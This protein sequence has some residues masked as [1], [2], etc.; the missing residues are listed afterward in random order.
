MHHRFLWLACALALCTTGCTSEAQRKAAA[1]A[2]EQRDKAECTRLGFKEDTEN[3]GNCILKL[4]EIRAEERAA[5]RSSAPY[6]YD[7]YPYNGMGLSWSHGWR[8]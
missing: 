5:I 8:R 6:Y 4:R 2:Q 7:P 3:F 1:E